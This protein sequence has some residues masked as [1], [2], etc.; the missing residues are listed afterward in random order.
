LADGPA[1]AAPLLARRRHSQDGP[2]V[3]AEARGR[4]GGRDCQTGTT[5]GGLVGAGA[6]EH[7]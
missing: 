7:E 1:P 3:T 6:T 5:P 4:W 2:R